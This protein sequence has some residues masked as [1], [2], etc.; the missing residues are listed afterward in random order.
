[1]LP[2]LAPSLLL[3]LTVV[4]ALPQPDLEKRADP[5]KEDVTFEQM[6]SSSATCGE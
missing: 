4:S 2:T 5:A 1:M 6:T 3:L